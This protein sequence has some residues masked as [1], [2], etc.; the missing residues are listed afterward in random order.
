MEHNTRPNREEQAMA[1]ENPV[2]KSMV[3]VAVNRYEGSH[4]RRPSGR[5]MWAF[6][7]GN[8]DGSIV[9]VSGSYSEAKREAVRLAAERGEYTVFVLP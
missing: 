5:G 4:G 3:V 9:W 1:S 7:F 6:A 2:P 8:P